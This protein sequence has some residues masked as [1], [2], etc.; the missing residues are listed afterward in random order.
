MRTSHHFI[1]GT[2]RSYCLLLFVIILN[3]SWKTA[4]AQSGTSMYDAFPIPINICSATSFSDYQNNAFGGFNDNF[5]NPNPDV[6][7]TFTFTEYTSFTIS[8]CGS[9]FDTYLYVLDA[10]GNVVSSNDDYGPLCGDSNASISETFAPGVYF[11]VAEGSG[12]NTGDLSV[13]VY[14]SGVGGTAAGANVYNAINAGT[15]GT[16]GSFFDTRSNADNCLGNDI[17]QPSNDIYYQFTLTSSSDV[18]LSHCGSNIDTY[19]HLIAQSGMVISTNDDGPNLACPGTAAYIKVTLPPGIYYLVSEGSGSGVGDIATSISVSPGAHGSAPVIAYSGIPNFSI[20]ST[21][22]PLSP[23]NTGGAVSSGGQSTTTFAGT[24]SSGSNN[25][26]TSFATFNNPLNSAVDAAGNVYIA[27]AGNS[28]IR[29]INPSGIVSTFAGAG[30]AGYADGTGTAAVFRHPSFIAID[31]TGTLFVSDQQNHRIRKISPSGVVSSFVGSGSIGSANGTG[32]AASFQYPMGM[33]FDAS[34]N[35]F[36]ADAYNHK[37]R[38]I[39]PSGVVSDFAGSGAAGAANGAGA[40][41]SFNRPMGLAFDTAGNLYVA[42]RDNAMI[43]KITPAGVVSTLAGSLP[44]G[45]VDGPGNVAKLNTNNLIVDADGNIYVVDQGNNMIRKVSPSGEVSTLAGSLTAGDANGTGSIVLFNSPFGI[46]K[47]PDDAMYIVE[48]AA[49]R[50][51]KMVLLKA[52]T[53]RPALPAGLVFNDTNG[54]ISGTPTV[55]SPLTTYAITAYNAA[56]SHTTTIRFAVTANVVCVGA[57]EDQ[58]YIMSYVSREPGLTTAAAII[59]ASCNPDLVQTSIEYFDGLGRPLQKVQVKGSP[60]KKDIVLPI[61]YDAF[62][63]ENKKYLPYASTEFNGAYREAGLTEVINYYNVPRAGQASP[64]NTPFSETRFEALPSNRV[65]EQGAPGSAWQIATDNTGHTSKMEYGA[66]LANDVKLWTVTSSGATAGFY[67]ANTLYKTT[68]KDENWIVTDVKAGTID[69]YKDFDG[70]VVLKRIWETDTRCLSTYYV[71]DNLGN[72]RYVLPPAVN[73]NTDRLSGA[74][75]SFIE[76]DVEFKNFMYGYH[77]DGKNRLVE[78]KFPGKDWEFI[79]YNTF[80]QVILTQDWK[81][82]TEGK[83]LMTKYDALGRV[84]LTG[85]YNDGR[86]RPEIQAA[87]ND[88]IIVNPN[89]RWSEEKSGSGEGY[90]NNV[91]PQS[92]SYYHSLN[93]YDDYNFPGNVFGQPDT[94]LGQM[95][96]PHT[97]GLLTG[98]SITVLGTGTMLLTVNYYD[99]EGRMIQ[100]KAQ[101]YKN[102]SGDVNNYDEVSNV[103]S[104]TDE[105]KESTRRHFNGGVETLYVYNK[106]QYDHMGRKLSTEQKTANNQL[107][108]SGL[109]LVKLSGNS[110]NETGQLLSKGQHGTGGSSFL[111]S[112]GYTY[113]ERGW[114]KTSASSLFSMELRYQDTGNPHYDRY[115]GDIAQQLYTNNLSNTFTY[116]YDKLNRLVVSS[117]GNGLGEGISYD[118]MGN[119]KTLN[120]DNYGTN[121][122]HISQYSGN[123]LKQISGFTNGSYTYNE[124]GNLEVDGPNGNTITYNYLNLPMQ[125]MGNQNV[126]YLYDSGGRKLRKQSG[127]M[128]TTDYIDGIHYKPD[129]NIDYVQ[130]EEGIARNNGGVYSYEYNQIDHQGNVRLSFYRNPS[131]ELLEVLQRDDYYAFGQRKAVGITGAN[132]YLYNG[133]E[134]QEELGTAGIGQLDYGA[135]FYDP[136]IGRWNVMDPKAELGRRW[137]P[138]AYAFDNPIYFIDPDGMWPGPGPGF[139]GGVK[140]G[141]TGYFGN[142]KQAVLNPVQTI[143]SQF[144]PGAIKENVLNT[145]TF[146]TYGMAKQ[147]LAVSSAASKGDL[148]VLGHAVGTKLAEGAVVLATEGL[149]KGLG[150]L[151]GASPAESITLY[152]GVNESHP[153]FSNAVDGVVA[154]RGGLATAAEHNAGNTASNFTSWTTNPDV[155]KNYALRPNGSGVT[156]EVTVPT[157]STVASPS[158]LNIQLRGTKTVVNESEVLLRGRTTGAKVT[159][160]QP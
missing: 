55:V 11:I 111:E 65:L 137:S 100:V 9:N 67:A 20:G 144:T 116:T 122:Y 89:Y 91:F 102:N 110:Y 23:I 141:F 22:S 57:S 52:Y 32:T 12:Y 61:A 76:S 77:Y 71:Y 134:L 45:Y 74:V 157:S 126:T 60:G 139:W 118:V 82:R 29:K 84:I 148:S 40:S 5:G 143:K 109:P 117:A 86:T 24:G 75:N 42:D 33:A 72:L 2:T 88:L 147:G 130:T 156:L 96:A 81:Q 160:V 120:R 93:Y 142:I 140:Q 92:I 131:T 44:R 63:R 39:T 105:L 54:T 48:N 124:N 113:N 128:G 112:T 79:I 153:G 108:A 34:G 123:Q 8:L 133:K 94:T 13:D 78:K 90:T 19:M 146:G 103:Y 58:N 73:E 121:D 69:E 7:Y 125:V 149:A 129:G 99:V 14:V 135:R 56:G 1:S 68:M 70:R 18:T 80:D 59:A 15:F 25:G 47:G 145:A 115:N 10:S 132:K 35:L 37:I 4:H 85:L 87:V 26:N 51:R 64:F 101:H 119:I 41:A 28:M 136:V 152:R 107:A 53:I 49:N 46:S 43:R 17:G 27:D 98:S 127:S 36:V 21:I 114:L 104:F 6:W 159:P 62:G 106:Y 151:K 30:Y 138:Y 38:K 16:T 155:A 3:M 31:A 158:L 154:P 95:Q 66:N 50:I 97:K 150:S 83:W